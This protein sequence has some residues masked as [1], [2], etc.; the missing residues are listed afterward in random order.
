MH[1][2]HSATPAAQV[3]LYEEA[4]FTVQAALPTCSGILVESAST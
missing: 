1:S 4:G 3:V 2:H